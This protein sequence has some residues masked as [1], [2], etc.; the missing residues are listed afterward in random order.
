MSNNILQLALQNQSSSTGSCSSRLERDAA[1]EVGV[2]LAAMGRVGRVGTSRGCGIGLAALDETTEGSVDRHGKELDKHGRELD[3]TYVTDARGSL[4]T[5][6]L[7]ASE[8]A[9]GIKV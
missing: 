8:D 2:K 9:L 4:L 5:T 1:L 6:G 3:L 7:E